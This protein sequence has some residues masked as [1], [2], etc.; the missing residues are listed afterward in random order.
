MRR[1]ALLILALALFLV[2]CGAAGPTTSDGS[3]T[4]TASTGAS[5]A[6]AGSAEGEGRTAQFP[7]PIIVYERSGGLV[8]GNSKWTIHTTGLIEGDENSTVQLAA[9]L[10]TP[11]FELVQSETFTQLEPTYGDPDRCADCI[12]HT[13]TVYGED[14]PQQVVVVEGSAELPSTLAEALSALN[15]VVTLQ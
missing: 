12:T 15:K 1:I 9:E 8:G 14:E 7:N 5:D 6:E 11:L 4:P 2:G 13:I 3:G 10:V